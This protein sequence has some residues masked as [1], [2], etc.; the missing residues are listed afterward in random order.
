MRMARPRLAGE[1]GGLGSGGKVNRVR[2]QL[3]KIRRASVGLVSRQPKPPPQPPR[4]PPIPSREGGVPM[5][6][7]IR[8]KGVPS[9]ISV[10][11]MAMLPALIPTAAGH[12]AA[13]AE[14]RQREAGLGRGGG[15]AGGG[16]GGRAGSPSGTSSGSD[17]TANVLGVWTMGLGLLGDRE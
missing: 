17:G 5:P 7:P 1:G 14:E 9:T 8:Q 10:L 15:G 3:D 11:P 2:A 16:G 12:R 4:P 6:P 13:E